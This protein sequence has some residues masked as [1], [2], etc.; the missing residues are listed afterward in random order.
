[1]KSQAE[2]WKPHAVFVDVTG[3]GAGVVDRLEQLG[4]SVTGIEFGGR[5]SLRETA[6]RLARGDPQQPAAKGAIPAIAADRSKCRHETL[7]GHVFGIVLAAVI[8]NLLYLCGPN[9]VL[10]FSGSKR[11]LGNRLY[12]YRLIKGARGVRVPAGSY[13]R[14]G[15]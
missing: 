14:R 7:L 8:R 11:R 3:V 15:R 6:K 9:E 10:I 13:A 12:G 4:H 2:K 5:P 1:M